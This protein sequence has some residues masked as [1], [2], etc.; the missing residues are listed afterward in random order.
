MKSE[1]YE[2]FIKKHFLGNPVVHVILVH[3]LIKDG[4]ELR[5]TNGK[6]TY[7]LFMTYRWNMT[8]QWC[9]YYT[10]KSKFKYII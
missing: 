9:G 4:Y 8:H 10:E 2:P 3:G 5:L 6:F 7:D 1:E